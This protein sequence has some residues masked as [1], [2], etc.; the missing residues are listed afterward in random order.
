MSWLWFRPVGRKFV[1][2]FQRISL[3]TPIYMGDKSKVLVGERVALANTVL[4]VS[5][6]RIT[7]GDRT[8]FSPNVMLV[9]GRHDFYEGTRVSLH[10]EFD[11]GSWGG[12]N[13]EVPKSG[14]D[15]HIGEG[16]WL[17][18]GVI[19]IGG[20]TL[21]NHLIVAAGAV[22]TH[23]FPDYAIVGG[24]PARQIGDTRNLPHPRQ[25]EIT[26]DQST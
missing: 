4:N 3:D 24:V 7:I 2:I 9:T 10:P 20:V 13:W 19:V 15:I 8:I 26:D 11:D 21:G 23:D 16:C 1:S 12:S 6:G 5:S 25:L 18:A 14:G 22:V 17:C